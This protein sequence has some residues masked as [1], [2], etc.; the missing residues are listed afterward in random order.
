MS[1]ELLCT[2]WPAG[3][4]WDEGGTAAASGAVLDDVLRRLN[5]LAFYAR[6]PPKSLGREWL[7]Q[8]VL[9]IVDDQ[10]GTGNLQKYMYLQRDI[11]A[12][13]G[14]SFCKLFTPTCLDAD[15]LRQS[16]NRLP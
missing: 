12:A 8:N 2:K 16:L 5:E 11:E 4:Q 9:P 13:S 14:M 7:E 3:V 1:F 10:V 15:S 6:P